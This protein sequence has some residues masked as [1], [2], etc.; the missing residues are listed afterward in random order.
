MSDE[1]LIY[2]CGLIPAMAILGRTFYANANRGD[3]ENYWPAM[4]G[5]AV[6]LGTAWPVSIPVLIVYFVMTWGT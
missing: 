1:L 3:R 6:I 4:L 5:T 2:L